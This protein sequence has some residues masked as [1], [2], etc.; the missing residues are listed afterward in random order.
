MKKAKLSARETIMLVLLSVLVIGV[1]YYMA[2]L[3]PLNNELAKIDTDIAALQA[4]K[5]SYQEK[6][7]Q[8]N[9][10]QAELDKLDRSS[11]VAP[12]DNL[13]EV[14]VEL[15]KYLYENSMNYTLTFME[16]EATEEGTV[17]RVVEMEFE[18]RDYESARAMVND[19]TSSK[20]RCLVGNTSLST[21]DEGKDIESTV[22]SVSLTVTFF[23][24]A[25]TAPTVTE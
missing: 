18:C 5:E 24:I 12:H 8:M 10:M 3:T 4:E 16:P 9:R 13:V 1:V 15:D 22:V 11:E 19:L 25:E 14:L 17:R 6:L 23:E 2:F 20:W 7:A 21:A